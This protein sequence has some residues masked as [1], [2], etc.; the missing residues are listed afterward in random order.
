MPVT[1]E[2]V[3]QVPPLAEYDVAADPALLEG[4]ER[5]DAGWAVAEVHALG[6]LAGSEQAQEWGRLVNENEPVLRTHDR[7]GN[8]IDEVEFHPYWHELMDVAVSHGLHAA[9]WRDSRPG[10]H[11]ARAA[12][13]YVWGQV[14]A[15]HTCPISMTY[16]AVPALRFNPELA[17]RYEPLLAS[18]EYDFGLREPSTKRGL[19]AGMS[20]T[21]KQGGSD[22][23]ANTTTARPVGDGSYVIVGHKWFT[24]APMSD[25]FLTLA[26]APGG[27][28]CFLL[29][30]V[31]PD[32]SRNGIRLQR[33]K[34]KLG[35]RSNASSEIEYDDAIGWLIG[36]EGRGVRTIIEM[37]NNTRLDCAV[38]SASGMRYGAVRAVHHARHRQ[39]F[40]A[41]LVDQPL[42]GNVLADLVVESEAA[43]TVGM[44]LAAAT[45]RPGDE[46]EQAFRRLGLAVTKYWV[47]KRGPSHAVEA[48]EC[49][50]GNGYVEESGMPRLYREAPLMSIWE[51]SGNVAALDA[52]RAMAKQP[53]SV[54]AY[55]TEVEQAAGADA[56]LDDAVG[57]LR[58]ELSDLSDIEYRSRRLVESMAL[59]LQASLLVRHGA[60][61][62]ADAFCASR[63]GGD[64]GVAFGTLPSGVDTRAIIA[65]AEV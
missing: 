41:D 1:H 3:N 42:M 37:V 62:V 39:A 27:L 40:G 46:R 54:A 56:R 26:Q 24:S 23:R 58:K 32:G 10:A 51:G 47:C 31:L 20:M 29:P 21:E 63:L 15:G 18:T 17:E 30:R 34:D 13:M 8:R 4:L 25:M 11:A 50:G 6:R 12:K 22:V 43:T 28:S 55:F 5:A 60:P 2:V 44:R 57:R 7:V 49:L 65:R 35:N 45:D 9:P 16:A 48:L 61:A 33:L 19:I 52:L 38:G 64:W 36:E 59:V 14:D 53:E